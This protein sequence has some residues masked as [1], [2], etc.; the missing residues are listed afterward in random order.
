MYIPATEVYWVLILLNILYLEWKDY[1]LQQL[2][3]VTDLY[4]YKQKCNLIITKNYKSGWTYLK[5][6][7]VISIMN[8]KDVFG[9]YEFTSVHAKLC[10]G[11]QEIP[12]TLWF[13]KASRSLGCWINMS[14]LSQ[15]C[16]FSF[17][18]QPYILPSIVNAKTCAVPR[19][20]E[21]TCWSFRD[22]TSSGT[23]IWSSLPWPSL[24]PSP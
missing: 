7:S 4:I 13:L 6:C 2:F 1:Y 5:V 11:P 24:Q 14:E 23:L 8:G 3:L 17:L 21:T 18:P 20:T 12:I 9:A 16:L 15:I 19:L 10:V 22:S